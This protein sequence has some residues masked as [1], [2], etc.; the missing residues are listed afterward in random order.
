MLRRFQQGKRHKFSGFSKVY[1]VV[2]RRFTVESYPERKSETESCR[3]ESV[4]SL[5][6]V[7]RGRGFCSACRDGTA[8]RWAVVAMDL[9]EIRWCERKRLQKRAHRRINGDE[10]E[11]EE[12]SERRK[13]TEFHRFFSLSSIC[14]ADYFTFFFFRS[15]QKINAYLTVSQRGKGT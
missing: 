4:L 12:A 7:A 3:I 10:T 9:F 5:S 11:D 2:E 6:A 8:T 1:P 14:K 13:R 15:N